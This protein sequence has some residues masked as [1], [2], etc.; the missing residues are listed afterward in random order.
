M[1]INQYNRLS[2]QSLF[3]DY[4][5][6]QKISK[7]TV[8]CYLSDINNF[9]NW[10]MYYFSTN[11]LIETMTYQPVSSDDL[12]VLIDFGLLEQY[13]GY[14]C[15]SNASISSK[16]RKMNSVFKYCKFLSIRGIVALKKS[17]MQTLHEIAKDKLTASTGESISEIKCNNGL[18]KTC[19]FNS[20]H[21]NSFTNF[22]KKYHNNVNISHVVKSLS[23]IL[24]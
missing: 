23:N 3:E 20:D 15:H 10:L 7:N 13:V 19:S 12:V 17:E 24:T 22:L 16:L 14:L 2:K 18:R 5:L 21:K 4:L 8:L 11:S 6:S 9:K 1:N